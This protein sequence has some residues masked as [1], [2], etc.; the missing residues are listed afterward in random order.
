MSHRKK[1]P[2]LY[3]FDYRVSI[4]EKKNW[5]RHMLCRIFRPID[6]YHSLV[7][8]KCFSGVLQDLG[9]FLESPFWPVTRK[10][11]M[12]E[13]WFRFWA[14]IL[15]QFPIGWPIHFFGGLR[16]FEN[17][18]YYC[19]SFA[20]FFRIFI[21]KMTLSAVFWLSREYPREKN[22]GRHMLCRIFRPIDWHHSLVPKN[23]SQELFKI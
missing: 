7:P 8:Q 19:N 1:L 3:F 14:A 21:E 20:P 23:F 12:F 5:G 13:I 9:P 15:F 17:F 11:L 22:W 4:R 10:Q 2:Y 6:W 18:P 16:F